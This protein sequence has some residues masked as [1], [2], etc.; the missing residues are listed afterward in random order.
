MEI[1]IKFRRGKNLQIEL[2][3]F[4]EPEEM[5]AVAFGKDY[6]LKEFEIFFKERAAIFKNWRIEKR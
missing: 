5:Q 4:G 6:F 3:E 2:V 1:I